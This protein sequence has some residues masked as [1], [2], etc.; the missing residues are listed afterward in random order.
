VPQTR[1]PRYD[2]VDSDVPGLKRMYAKRLRA[3]AAIGY[4]TNDQLAVQLD[5]APVR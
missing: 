4:E 5:P 1:F 3:Y 2:Y